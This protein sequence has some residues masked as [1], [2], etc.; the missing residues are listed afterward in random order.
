MAVFSACFHPAA[1]TLQVRNP[2]E[3]G[4]E[5]WVRGSLLRI[6]VTEAYAEWGASITPHA[7]SSYNGFIYYQH[8]T[9]GD[10]RTFPEQIGKK[11]S[12][13]TRVLALLSKG[14]RR[15]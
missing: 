13:H 2:S 12:R 1:V 11:S 9:D 7:L 14:R 6:L 4:W 3:F 15:G 5:E 10:M 8:V